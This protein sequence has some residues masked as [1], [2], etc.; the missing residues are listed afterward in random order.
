MDHLFA[1]QEGKAW[2]PFAALGF[3]PFPSEATSSGCP[4]EICLEHGRHADDEISPRC[5]DAWVENVDMWL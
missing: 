2:L 4:M 5:Q 3:A 1:E